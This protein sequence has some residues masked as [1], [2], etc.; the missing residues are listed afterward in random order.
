[1]ASSTGL[2]AIN[3]LIT[4]HNAEGKAVFS[5]AVDAETPLNAIDK[6][7]GVLFGL[8]YASEQFP[9]QMNDDK[10]IQVYKQYMQKPP[11]IVI[12]GGTVLRTVDMP[13]G[14]LSPMHRTVSLD[15]GIV[16][17][18]DVE[19][20]LDSGET[21]AMKQGDI[22]IQ[23]GT[24]HAWRNLS[25]S[26]DLLNRHRTS[27][28]KSAGE[29]LRKRTGRACEACIKS[30]TKCDEARPC[31]RC[32]TRDQSCEETERR[33][34]S[35]GRPPSQQPSPP[36]IYRG[37][38]QHTLGGHE[39]QQ[40]YQQDR[41]G[42]TRPL[43]DTQ[44]GHVQP[45]TPNSFPT[46]RQL[47]DALLL[48][49]LSGSLVDGV[50][51]TQLDGMPIDSQANGFMLDES[52]F[53]LSGSLVD[54]TGTTQL[55]GMPVN[56]QA[57]GFTLE[58]SS[59]P[60]FFEHIMMPPQPGAGIHSHMTMPV[61]VSNFTQDLT[62][63][64]CDFDFSSF[65]ASGL[66][67]PS[68]SQGYHDVVE[69]TLAAETPQ[70]D[71]QLR[72]EAF[73]RSPW[74][75]NH[76]IPERNSHAFSSGQDEINVLQ[77]RVTATDQLTS[78]EST[79]S[80]H[81]ALDQAARDGMIRTVTQIAH[82]RLAMPSFP[83]LELLED[84]IDVFLIQ[85]SNA[86]DSYV[87]AATF[88]CKTMR[89][90]LLLAMVAAGARYIAL[91]PVWKMGLVIQEV[92]RLAVADVFERD[93]STTRELQATQAMLL[94]LD[95]GV[96]SGF[97]RKTEIALSFLQ[98]LVTMFSWSHSFERSR[99]KEVV[100][101]AGDT[102]DMLEGKWKAWAEQEGLKRLVIHTFLHDSRVA[103]IN[104]KNPLLSAA[105]MR[106]PLPAS[107][108]LWLAPNAHAWANTY[109]K[110][111][112]PFQPESASMTEFFG[113]NRLLEQLGDTVDKPL[114]ML[115]ACHG[116]GHEVWVFR[117]HAR[118]LS[119]WQNQGRR[120]RFLSLQTQQRDLYDDLSTFSVYC[121][122]E[123][124]AS[125]E[126]ML[127][128]EL[129]MMNLHVDL[130]DV[131][132][133]SGKSGEEEAR[134]V[135]PRIRAWTDSGEARTAV[136]HAGAVFRIARTFEQTRLRDFYALAFYQATLTLWV[137]GMVTNNTARKS[138]VQT[139]LHMTPRM[140]NNITYGSAYAHRTL[141]DAN[142]ERSAKSFTLLGQ[143]Q[144]GIQDHRSAFVPLTHSKGV[145]STAEAVL[146]SNFPQSSH[147]LPPLVENLANLMSELGKLSG[148]D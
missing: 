109:H 55:N 25:D 64:S 8:H 67:R 82:Q 42:S 75:W 18:G 129:L 119:D 33:R 85:D 120:D 53:G 61:D 57:D 27:H 140:A 115:A 58:Q 68:T 116:L 133:F 32:K 2:P 10:D 73:E 93:N 143:G 105:Q 77:D 113:N 4:T 126:I 117:Q 108:E 54:G 103:I 138:G 142:D 15:Y 136:R 50:G 9:V 38:E 39:A 21:R 83:S 60:D 107:R 146:K 132:T 79:H 26:N 78:P 22:A 98:P 72:S 118:L 90:E 35:L 74:S 41:T 114:C 144:P 137:Y 88:D 6:K 5:D 12:G 59:F 99:Y 101:T 81:C 94:W 145:M 125:P 121:E 106:L 51:T 52:N 147:G 43:N 127:T 135:F 14:S 24:N 112:L 128:V 66:T 100:P 40:D 3:R 1:M 139:P 131:Q 36:P 148:K 23:R 17:E 89:T 111:K 92:V 56:L 91:A 63:D 47:D 84:L 46:S 20:V 141:V 110:L 95:I 34:H 13:P 76:W 102:D 97:R 87:H 134:R 30:K 86:I 104:L 130:E 7:S 123:N 49:G 19:I 48:S 28:A 44:S 70:S 96:F 62:F 69:P 122:L 31:K 11:G 37:H 29:T 80:V 65:L 124:D 16:L 71:A 45:K